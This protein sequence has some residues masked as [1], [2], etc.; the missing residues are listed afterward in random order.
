MGKQVSRGGRQ[1]V[2]VF[3]YELIGNSQGLLTKEKFSTQFHPSRIF[4]PVA[5]MRR[6]GRMG[7]WEDE[8]T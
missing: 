4:S 6:G 2:S 8:R 3:V 7:G 5:G 1:L